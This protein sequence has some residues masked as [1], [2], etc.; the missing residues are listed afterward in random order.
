ML[1]IRLVPSEIANASPSPELP[2]L[3][4]L[5]P[6]PPIA[7]TVVETSGLGRERGGGWN[8]G[9]NQYLKGQAEREGA[10]NRLKEGGWPQR[11]PQKPGEI[12]HGENSSC[13]REGKYEKARKERTRFGKQ[14]VT[15]GCRDNPFTGLRTFEA[16][17]H[18][19]EGSNEP[20]IMKISC[21]RVFALVSPQ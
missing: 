5:S 8:L 3:V 17:R 1:Y 18:M 13:Q 2:S 21:K 12:L 6:H 14:A 19:G 15:D 7:D 4:L 20:V 16:L 11:M 9:E 10:S